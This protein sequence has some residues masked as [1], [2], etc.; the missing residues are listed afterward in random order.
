MDTG[1]PLIRG[2]QLVGILS[3]YRP[4]NESSVLIFTRVSIYEEFVHH[5]AQEVSD[6]DDNE[7]TWSSGNSNGSLSDK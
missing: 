5:E 6:Y 4:P 3:N 2:R 7:S 1:A